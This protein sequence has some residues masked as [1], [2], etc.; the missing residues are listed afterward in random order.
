MGQGTYQ[1]HEFSCRNCQE[2]MKVGMKVDYTNISTETLALEN[3]EHCEEVGPA[4]IV[5][6]DANF[7]VPN[8]MIDED[9]AFH[10]IF[11]MQEL[12]TKA[13]ERGPVPS[14]PIKKLLAGERPYR[15]PDY[16]DE[17]KHLRKAI[18]LHRNGKEKLSQRKISEATKEY[19]PNDPIA[20]VDDWM[21][22]L[23]MQLCQPAYEQAFKDIMG[24]V[25]AIVKVND[26]SPFWTYYQSNMR[27]E[28]AK[29][30]FDIIK[31]Y[32]DGYSD[33]SQVYN[34][35]AAGLEV[36]D[37][38][39]ATSA[40]FDNVKTFYGDAYETFGK[41]VEMLALLNNLKLGRNFDQF[42]NLTL[43]KYQQLDNSSKFNCFGLNAPFV[44]ICTEKDGQ[45]R[46]A[47]HHRGISISPDKSTIEYR[48]GKGGTGNLIYEPDLYRIEPSMF[49]L[50]LFDLNQTKTYSHRPHIYPRKI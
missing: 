41:T 28:R 16:E 19:Y 45:I 34:R 20:G 35:V 10:R 15:R 33:F 5:N 13:K 40:S 11:Q 44:A 7:T 17:W 21:W 42:E 39:V 43:K 25:S 14:V 3:A 30:Y 22:R 18:S 8:N 32:F 37:D 38:H 47:S 9:V 29:L 26:M 23:S 4:P 12:V 50:N 2:P 49:L 1:E 27:E 46:N 31:D 36:P 6:V 48:A 24:E